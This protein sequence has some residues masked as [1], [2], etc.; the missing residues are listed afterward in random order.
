MKRQDQRERRR[1]LAAECAVEAFF[2]DASEGEV[3]A[4]VH[5]R[6]TKDNAV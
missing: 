5:E 3:R 6:R 1:D 4:Y 2:E